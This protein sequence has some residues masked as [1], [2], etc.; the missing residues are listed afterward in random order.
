MLGVVLVFRLV[1]LVKCLKLVFYFLN[2][3][4]LAYWSPLGKDPSHNVGV[5]SL[6]LADEDCVDFLAMRN[7]RDEEE[8]EVRDPIDRVTVHH[9]RAKIRKLSQ[10]IELL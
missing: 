4:I 1:L 3:L 6:L 9:Q 8:S 7:H 2:D 10:F 5:V